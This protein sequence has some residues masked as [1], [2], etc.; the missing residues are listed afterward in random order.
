MCRAPTA[1]PPLICISQGPICFRP[2]SA[3][4]CNLSAVNIWIFKIWTEFERIW[5]PWWRELA[6]S[7]GGRRSKRPAPHAGSW[8]WCTGIGI[9]WGTRSRWTCPKEEARQKE[10]GQQTVRHSTRTKEHRDSMKENW[11]P[12]YAGFSESLRP[13]TCSDRVRP[14]R[15]Q[16]EAFQNYRFV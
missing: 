11:Q 4:N 2:I 13:G 5:L 15:C 10:H 6:P 12:M 3:F 1:P 8:T 14:N 7:V 16:T 9:G